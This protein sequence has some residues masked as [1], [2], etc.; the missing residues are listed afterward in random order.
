MTRLS[1]TAE[2]GVDVPYRPS[3]YWVR[4]RVTDTGSGVE[5]YSAANS[6]AQRLAEQNPGLTFEVAED[7]VWSTVR[8][9]VQEEPSGA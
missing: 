5:T 3:E 1:C 2:S 7:K 6:L 8:Y 9:H 4:V